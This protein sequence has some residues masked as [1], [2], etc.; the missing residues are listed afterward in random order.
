MSRF[1]RSKVKR[2]RASDVAH[3]Q[4]MVALT[5]RDGTVAAVA[6]AMTAPSE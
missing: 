4:S 2:M 1:Q 3:P 6:A 5:V